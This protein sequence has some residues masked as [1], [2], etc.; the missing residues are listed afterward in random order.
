MAAL[1]SLATVTR[2]LQQLSTPQASQ[3]APKPPK[4]EKYEGDRRCSTQ[5]PTRTFQTCQ[6]L[7][8]HLLEPSLSFLFYIMY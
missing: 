4:P 1:H 6:K 5:L 3:T 8:L 2:V 7:P